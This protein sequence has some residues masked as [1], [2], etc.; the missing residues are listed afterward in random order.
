MYVNI[1]VRVNTKNKLDAIR[2]ALQMKSYDE[3][4]NKMA[5]SCS[6]LLIKDLKGSLKGTPP[7]KRDKNDWRTFD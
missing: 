1:P 7:F 2:E 3:T 4:V 6:Y 5:Q